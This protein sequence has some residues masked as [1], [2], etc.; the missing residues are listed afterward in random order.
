MSRLQAS[1]KTFPTPRHQDISM[2]FREKMMAVI[3]IGYTGELNKKR[4][5][6]KSAFCLLIWLRDFKQR[7]PSPDTNRLLAEF[8]LERLGQGRDHR[9]QVADHAVARSLEDGRIGVLVDGDDQLARAHP[10]HV[11]DGP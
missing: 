8:F 1:C 10:R 3:L 7:F 2:S 6:Y 4:P 11:L 5:F 9:E